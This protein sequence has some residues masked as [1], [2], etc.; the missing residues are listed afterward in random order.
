MIRSLFCLIVVLP[1]ILGLWVKVVRMV[2]GML[3]C[4]RL[5]RGSSDLT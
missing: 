2:R 4:L 5:G 1:L 3:G